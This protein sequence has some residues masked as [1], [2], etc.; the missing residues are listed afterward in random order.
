MKPKELIKLLEKE[1]W[2]VVRVDGSHHIMKHAD[3]PAM[4]VV[5][6]HN[7]DMK[8]GIL[9]NIMKTAGLKQQ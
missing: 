8:P 3:K 4:I 1:G 7:K 6:L 5:P 9:N 2:L